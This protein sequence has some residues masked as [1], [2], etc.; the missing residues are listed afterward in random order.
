MAGTTAAYGGGLEGGG[1]VQPNQLLLEGG[2]QSPS[3]LLHPAPY[4]SSL[5]LFI[6]HIHT[7]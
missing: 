7:Q 2:K 5:L 4:Y 6:P 1:E 3:C